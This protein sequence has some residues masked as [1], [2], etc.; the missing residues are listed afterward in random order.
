[1]LLLL[2]VVGC[3]FIHGRWILRPPRSHE[4][5]RGF[6]KN[7]SHL[8]DLVMTSVTFLFEHRLLDDDQVD[9]TMATHISSSINTIPA[10]AAAVVV[11]N[12]LFRHQ[13]STTIR[14]PRLDGAILFG[15]C[16][17]DG[18]SGGV[19]YEQFINPYGW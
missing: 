11:Q 12:E 6:T 9:S 15:V 17:Q 10:A 3:L 14:L 1:M 5:I 7:Q 16:P 4:L 19:H 18:H 8:G 2:P 13:V